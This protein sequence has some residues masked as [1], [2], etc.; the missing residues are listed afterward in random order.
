[1]RSKSVFVKR[2]FIPVRIY[3]IMN[4][5]SFWETTDG[6]PGHFAKDDYR[7][8]PVDYTAA[9]MTPS[10]FSASIRVRS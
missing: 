7:T 10:A 1:M 5:R 4:G 6:S 3:R 2:N 9:L 8:Q